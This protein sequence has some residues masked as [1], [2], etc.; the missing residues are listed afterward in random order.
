MLKDEE[1]KGCFHGRLLHMAPLYRKQDKKYSSA[2]ILTKPDAELSSLNSYQHQA[3]SRLYP[4]HGLAA[5]CRCIYSGLVLGVPYS[6]EIARWVQSVVCPL[7]HA[8]MVS[9]SSRHGG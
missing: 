2:V 1:L 8:N 6:K 4:T 7:A 9:S 3:N 5:R